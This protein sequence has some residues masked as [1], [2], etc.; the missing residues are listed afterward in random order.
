VL[1]SDSVQLR[2][3]LVVLPNVLVGE[4]QLSIESLEPPPVFFEVIR[5]FVSEL[6]GPLV[7]FLIL[8]VHLVE[9]GRR[10]L[11]ELRPLGMDH[12]ELVPEQPDLLLSFGETFVLVRPIEAQIEEVVHL[13]QRYQPRGLIGSV[14]LTLKNMRG[15]HLPMP[16]VVAR[17]FLRVLHSEQLL[18]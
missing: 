8:D 13:V 9:G 18:D 12:F 2:E 15:R 10:L 6:S 1:V 16:N 4:T 5:H 7:L 17:Q 3:V 14:S 11:F